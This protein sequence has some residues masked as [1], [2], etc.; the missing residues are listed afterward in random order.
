M[1]ETVRCER[2]INFFNSLSNSC[3]FVRMF[4]DTVCHFR[5]CDLCNKCFGY[6]GT[7][8]W[9]LQRHSVCL[10]QHCRVWRL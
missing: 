8:T 5:Q 6:K 4:P 7:F 9:E 3:C 10:L 1:L 2:F